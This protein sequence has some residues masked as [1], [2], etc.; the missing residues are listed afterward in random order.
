MYQGSTPTALEDFLDCSLDFGIIESSGQPLS[1]TGGGGCTTNFE[2]DSV[3][4][5]DGLV[6]GNGLGGA[7]WFGDKIMT[8][9]FASPVTAAGLVFTDGFPSTDT[10]FS[11][12]APGG[13]P[14]GT[15]GPFVL[16]DAAFNS[17]TAEDRFFGVRNPNGIGSIR[18]SQPAG[19]KLEI[20]HVQYG[21]IA[22]LFATW[23]EA[24]AL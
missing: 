3:D 21:D 18:I 5:D 4:G 9:T 12:Y 13:A 14:L 17:L 11:A 20:D 19:T 2:V 23:D 15:I 22:T 7:S 6:D 10:Y 24:L 16:G 8:F 1:S